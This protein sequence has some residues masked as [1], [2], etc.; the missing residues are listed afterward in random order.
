MFD[1]TQVSELTGKLNEA[2]PRVFGKRN[3]DGHE[4]SIKT[5]IDQTTATVKFEVSVTDTALAANIKAAI[6]KVLK[7]EPEAHEEAPKRARAT[8]A[9]PVEE[10]PKRGRGRP[11]KE[12]AQAAATPAKRGPKPVPEW[13]NELPTTFKEWGVEGYAT[14]RLINKAINDGD[15]E[16]DTAII[17]ALKDKANGVP[18]PV[19]LLKDCKAAGVSPLSL[20]LALAGLDGKGLDKPFSVEVK[21]A[22]AM[23]V[24]AEY[25]ES[26]YGDESAEDDE[27]FDDDD[28][29]V[30]GDDDDNGDDGDDDEDD[31]G[32]EDDDADDDDDD[33]DDN[34]DDDEDYDL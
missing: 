10:A 11:P 34:D 9:A 2:L 19:A 15:T 23:P 21:K 25:V 14:P 16:F 20:L 6:R 28:D 30:E 12:E 24:V 3:L 22:A 1:K 33:D 31:F 32:D 29:Y 4:L 13:M 5:V 26:V 18:K 7:G 27:D 8:A 17:A